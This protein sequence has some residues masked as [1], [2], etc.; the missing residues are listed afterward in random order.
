L[1]LCGIA[2]IYYTTLTVLFDWISTPVWTQ[3][4]MLWGNLWRKE[5]KSK[6]ICTLCYIAGELHSH[7][8][9][10]LQGSLLYSV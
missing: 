1:K 6:Q 8:L 3:N 4:T 7:N 9:P 2:E 10:S 5:R